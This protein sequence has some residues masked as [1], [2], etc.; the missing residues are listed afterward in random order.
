MADQTVTSY[1]QGQSRQRPLA[2]TKLPVLRLTRMLNN[3]FAELSRE[4]LIERL[5]Q[6]GGARNTEPQLMAVL[7]ELGDVRAALDE[8]SIVAI[9]DAS[10]KITQ[11]NDKF[12]AISKYSREELIGQDHR[13]I[14][15]RHHSR[16]FFRSL[17]TTI[18]HG[19]VWRGEICNRAK[20][21]SLYWV[22]T[23]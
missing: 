14:N 5:R 16:E 7:K 1:L 18:A 15:S 12:C 23:T 17:W 10:G 9:T 6:L 20:D 21:G 13:I 4:E 3:D 19:K 2:R 11:V 8:H 22:D